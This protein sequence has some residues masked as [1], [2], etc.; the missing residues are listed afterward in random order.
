MSELSL[1]NI[2]EKRNEL[3]KLINGGFPFEIEVNQ[4]EIQKGF[5]GFLRKKITVKKNYQFSIK[6]LPLSVLDRIS[7]ESL[8]IN[9]DEF[10][11]ED[12]M[13]MAKK[14]TRKYV[15]KMAKIIAI[16][17]LGKDYEYQEKDYFGRII[18]KTDDEELRRL[19]E[20]FF[21]TLKPSDLLYLIELIDVSSNLSDF[22][23]STRLVTAASTIMEK[24]K[25][26]DLVEE[27]LPH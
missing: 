26:A 2:T 11:G 22:I 14:T 24:E 9:V 27:R 23:S 3:V 12:A 6:E 25:T 19:T 7:I 5:W 8:E 20:L 21:R 18:Y 10:S 13:N 4:K 16:A 15:K 17:V 1:E